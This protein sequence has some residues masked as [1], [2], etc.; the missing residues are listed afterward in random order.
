VTVFH[1][2][3]P[4]RRPSKNRIIGGTIGEPALQQRLHDLRP[5]EQRKLFGA[6]IQRRITAGELDPGLTDAAMSYLVSRAQ[7]IVPLKL[8]SAA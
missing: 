5:E 2:K 1:P 8:V 6:E 3:L 4:F 7:Q